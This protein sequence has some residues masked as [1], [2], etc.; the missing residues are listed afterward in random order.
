LFAFRLLSPHSLLSLS[1]V[2]LFLPLL[3][4]FT[5][6]FSHFLC[7]HFSL[8]LVLLS[9]IPW[10]HSFP[11]VFVLSAFRL[12]FTLSPCHPCFPLSSLSLFC[13]F[14]GSTFFWPCM[15][16]AYF[17]SLS[18]PLLTNSFLPIR[19]FHSPN[20][21]FSGYRL[22]LYLSIPLFSGYTIFWP[23]RRSACLF[24]SLTL[25][26]PFGLFTLVYASPVSSFA[27]PTR[28]VR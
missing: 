13:P 5:L 28:P 17:I 10:L 22:S 27:S 11:L 9:F 25:F 15:R 19:S 16:S 12:L 23:C 8:S 2:L 18:T 7:P 24:P 6:L 4:G 14:L 26:C 21:L 1:L 20:P 3:P